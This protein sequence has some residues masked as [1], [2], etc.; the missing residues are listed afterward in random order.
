MVLA[1]PNRSRPP[2]RLVGLM[3]SIRDGVQQAHSPN[4][5]MN[6]PIFQAMTTNPVRY[7]RRAI[8]HSSAAY[9]VVKVSV[10]VSNTPKDRHHRPLTENSPGNV[11]KGL[12][13]NKHGERLAKDKE[14]HHSGHQ[15]HA[16]DVHRPISPSSGSITC[17]PEPDKISNDTDVSHHSLEFGGEK[18]VPVFV[19]DVAEST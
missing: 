16:K 12:G 18:L 15:D 1:K 7:P 4:E 5:E 9:A 3:I 11:D 8:G 14:E 6:C 10:T 13:N 19:D 2:I 17:E